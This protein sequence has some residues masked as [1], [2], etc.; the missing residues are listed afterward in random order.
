[1]FPYGL[2]E[3]IAGVV[4][5]HGPFFFRLWIE[6]MKSSGNWNENGEAP[7]VCGCMEAS[8]ALSDHREPAP[9]R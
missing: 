3:P 9:C 5:S 2:Q 4:T 6:Q 1:V 7:P 8:K